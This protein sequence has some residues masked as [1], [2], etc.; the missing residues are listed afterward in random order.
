MSCILYTSYIQ[1]YLHSHLIYCLSA[2]ENF[3]L[4]AVISSASC[5]PRLC[6]GN[7]SANRKYRVGN[8]A[9]QRRRRAGHRH[10][11]GQGQGKCIHHTGRGTLVLPPAEVRGEGRR[12]RGHRSSACCRIHSPIRKIRRTSLLLIKFPQSDCSPT[13]RG[14]NFLTTPLPCH[15]HSAFCPLLKILLGFP[16]TI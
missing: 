12:S 5:W 8:V 3:C 14:V 4:S 15:T 6:H 1:Y 13:T 10:F 16:C 11:M 2:T 7:E 9:G